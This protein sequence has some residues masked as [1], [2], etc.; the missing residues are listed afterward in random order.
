M[1]CKQIKKIKP[2]KRPK[3][4]QFISTEKLYFELAKLSKSFFISKVV[5]K[6][7]RQCKFSVSLT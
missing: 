2:K 1:L 7:K 6:N 4:Y 3:N 5:N